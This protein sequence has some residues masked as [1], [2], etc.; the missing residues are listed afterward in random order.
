[1]IIKSHKTRLSISKE[2]RIT[3]PPQLTVVV[4]VVAPTCGVFCF[5][6]HPEAK[7]RTVAT[8]RDRDRGRQ[9]RRQMRYLQREASV[10]LVWHCLWHG[11]HVICY[12]SGIPL[13]SASSSAA[14][15]PM[16]IPIPFKYETRKENKTKA[17]FPFPSL[18]F[19]S[20]SILRSS[21]QFCSV[22]LCA[23]FSSRSISFCNLPARC[24]FVWCVYL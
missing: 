1:M 7:A 22:Y 24:F 21:L 4:V 20:L 12:A 6:P 15:D 2:K 23:R 19:S 9:S 14:L 18:Q 11:H 17:A 10:Q 16:P 8:V 13:P 3:P 5:V